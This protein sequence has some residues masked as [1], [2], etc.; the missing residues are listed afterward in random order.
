MIRAGLAEVYRGKP[1]RGFDKEPYLKAEAE[2]RQA[3]KGMWSLGDR[4]ISPRDWRRM[5]RKK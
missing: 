4:Y 1:F 3:K 5:N 2:A